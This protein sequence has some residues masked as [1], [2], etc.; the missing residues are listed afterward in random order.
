MENQEVDSNLENESERSTEI[1]YKAEFEKVQATNDRLLSESKKNKAKAGDSTDLK[2]RL[3][4]MEQ[5]KVDREGSQ[6]ERIA[7]Y[8]KQADEFKEQV[9]GLRSDN[10]KASLKDSLREVAPDCHNIKKGG[11]CY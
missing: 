5:E 2:N 10:L 1:D 7:H 11:R 8:K 6:D 4:L 3:A 9:L